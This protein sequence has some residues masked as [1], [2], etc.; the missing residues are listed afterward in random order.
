MK[1]FMYLS[2]GVLCLMLAALI[3]FHLGQRSAHAQSDT[4]TAQRFVLVDSTGQIRWEWKTSLDRSVF[5]MF[6]SE[7][8]HKARISVDSSSASC[9]LSTPSSSYSAA[10]GDYAASV[11]LG[12]RQND[13]PDTYGHM[14]MDVTSEITY[15]ALLNPVKSSI[16]F[17]EQGGK[18]NRNVR[19]LIL[20]NSARDYRLVDRVSEA[21]PM[22]SIVVVGDSATV[23]IP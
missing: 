23:T 12:K 16:E 6:D 4:I 14:W 3:G 10:A 7:R 22:A 15:M 20:G 5:R 19:R 21:R 8:T 9:W 13:D 1:R 17:F 11:H 18:R 2:I